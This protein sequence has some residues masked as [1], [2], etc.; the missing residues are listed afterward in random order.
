[1]PAAAA[2][3]S[4]LRLALVLLLLLLWAACGA[5][6][7]P[8]GQHQQ[9]Q[10]AFSAPSS[11]GA[12]AAVPIKWS[13]AELGV[14]RLES[15]DT[16]LGKAFDA[17]ITVGRKNE[18]GTC[19]DC[20]STRELLSKGY[21]AIYPRDIATLGV[22]TAKCLG[23]EAL[24]SARQARA[25]YMPAPPF[26]ASLIEILPA[27]LAPTITPAQQQAVASA[28]MAG[29]PLRKVEVTV[30]FEAARDEEIHIAGEGWQE[31]L[32]LLGRA[33]FDSD[34]LQDWLV[35]ADLAMERGTNRVSRL[36]LFTRDSSRVPLRTIRELKP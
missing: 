23:L 27:D 19:A 12:A 3:L 5:S 35:R 17:P 20:A 31:T 2:P 7:N 15:I 16:E 18:R 21:A 13:S 14:S 8:E 29:Q 11:A 25:S 22:L 24:K 33:D 9:Q 6:S 34:G 30:A 28:S 10:P 36:F 1:M 4:F 32:V 26:N